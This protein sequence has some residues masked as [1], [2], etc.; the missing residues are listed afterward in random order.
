MSARYCCNRERNERQ[1]YPCAVKKKN[2]NFF[3]KMKHGNK[4]GGKNRNKL[5]ALT[6]FDVTFYLPS[7]SN[8]NASRVLLYRGVLHRSVENRFLQ[9]SM[10]KNCN[11]NSIRI[12]LLTGTK[13]MVVTFLPCSTLCRYEIS[14]I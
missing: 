8:E 12:I 4:K 11:S 3:S 10:L 1:W 7:R 14:L 13:N 2:C 5:D 6:R 9:C